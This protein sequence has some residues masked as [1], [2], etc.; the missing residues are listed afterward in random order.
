M[1]NFGS[2]DI[3]PIIL[4]AVTLSVAYLTVAEKERERVRIFADGVDA[5]KLVIYE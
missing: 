4:I 3:I 1:E 5:L 2:N